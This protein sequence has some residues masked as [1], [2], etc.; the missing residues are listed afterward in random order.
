MGVK[1]NLK[2]KGSVGWK[3]YANILLLTVLAIAISC[4]SIY[5][6]GILRKTIK[7]ESEIE[8]SQMSVL[9]D[10]RADIQTCEKYF[11]EYLY[12]NSATRR[13]IADRGFQKARK[14]VLSSIDEMESIVTSET[15]EQLQDITILVDS[16]FSVMDGVMEE[17]DS[18]DNEIKIRDATVEI[19]EALDTI[20]T[21][22]DA[23]C[24]DTISSMD[25]SSA[26]EEEIFE[27]NNMVMG[28]FIAL[29]IAL[30]LVAVCIVHF[31]VA[32]PFNGDE[33]EIRGIIRKI[34]STSSNIQNTTDTINENLVLANSNSTS[35]SAMTQE[36][37]ESM[38]NVASTTTSLVSDAKNMLTSIKYVSDDETPETVA[39]K[40]EKRTVIAAQLKEKRELLEKAIEDAKK[41]EEISLMTDDILDIASQTTLL[42]LNASIEAAHAGASGHDVAL[43]AEEIRCLADGSRK[44]ANS[45]R[46]ISSRATGAVDSLMTGTNGLL[47]Y[48]DY[49]S[50]NMD[51]LKFATEQIT[52]SLDTVAE[53]INRCSRG[54]TESTQN[55]NSLANNISEIERDTQENCSRLH[56][57]NQEI[58]KFQ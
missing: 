21:K 7:S 38:E 24:E 34:V 46:Q 4:S 36:I 23:M 10:L 49:F 31:D 52:T 28:T 41:I 19:Q 3:L 1:K 11:F 26:Q 42:A 43:I 5:F 44:K 58:R 14:D 2:R 17:D 39:V 22:V 40:G 33:K 30:S 8:K 20:N 29:V 48:V 32:R 50:D 57:L 9:S 13:G 37:S 16:T 25:A 6:S 27:R 15:K 51:S 35:I 55:I 12:Y 54:V 18:G 47:E 56:T 45:I 53:S